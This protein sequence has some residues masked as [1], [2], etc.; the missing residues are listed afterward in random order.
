MLS[1]DNT[2]LLVDNSMLSADN[3]MLSTDNIELSA[4]NTIRGFLRI[5]R[6]NSAWLLKLKLKIILAQYIIQNS[7]L[8]SI[9]VQ[10]WNLFT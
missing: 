1:P 9:Q 3:T 7:V 8:Q 6:H 2:L 4:Y 5:R 10:A